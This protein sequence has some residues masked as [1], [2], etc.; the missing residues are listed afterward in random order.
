MRRR[1]AVLGTLAALCAAGSAFVFATS[2]GAQDTGSTAPSK[3][4]QGQGTPPVSYAPELVREGRTLFVEGCSTCHGMNAEGIPNV[5]PDLRGVGAQAADF[6]VSTGRMPLDK[7]GDQPLRSHPIY[8]QEQIDAIVAYIGSLG[9]PP[10]PEVHPERGTLS[11]GLEL[12]SLYCAGCHQVT[13]QGGVVTDAFAPDLNEATAT[14]I[15]EAARVGPY[16]MPVFNEQ[17]IS[18]QQLDSIVRYVQFAQKPDNKGGWGIGNIGP[19]TEGMVAWFLGGVAL[20]LC[21]RLIG[22]R[23]EERNGL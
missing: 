16:V 21:A 23:S 8:T 11:E 19:I 5:A 1:R 3:E 9:G 10:I 4:S 15:A 18:A 7:P 14:Q 13:V 20:L 6:Y 17:L 22:E 2:G 12:F